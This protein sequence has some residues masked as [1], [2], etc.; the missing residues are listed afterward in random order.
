M[1]I[2]LDRNLIDTL[3]GMEDEDLWQLCCNLTNEKKSHSRKNPDYGMIRRI[4]AVL[5]AVENEDIERIN[6]FLAIYRS[7]K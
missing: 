6:R 3:R 1:R 5:D 7:T 2:I 4:R